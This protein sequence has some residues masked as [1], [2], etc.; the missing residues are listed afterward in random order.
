VVIA[1]APVV[2]AF[3]AHIVFWALLGIG[4]LYGAIRTK[5]IALFLALWIIGYAALPRFDGNSGFLM[6]AW[7]AMLDIA[8]V[9]ILFGGDVRI[10]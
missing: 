9:L 3:I 8:L 2:A 4:I 6:T 5:G 10:T 7:L 1:G